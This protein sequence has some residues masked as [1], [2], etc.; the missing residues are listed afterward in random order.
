MRAV[1]VAALIASTAFADELPP[2]PLTRAHE[3]KTGGILSTS[4][5]L[6]AIALGAALVITA[7]E[8]PSCAFRIGDYQP[9]PNDRAENTATVPA[10]LAGG[11]MLSVLGDV[12]LL[13][14]APLWSVGAKREDRLRAKIALTPTGIVGRF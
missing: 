8:L 9:C 4:V 12:F 13:V 2:D 3:M 1:I 10:L 7:F 11:V 14:G 5:G 6:V